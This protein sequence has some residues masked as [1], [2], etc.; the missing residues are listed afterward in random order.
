MTSQK[1]D[2]LIL[3]AFGL[4]I[5]ALYGLGDIDFGE[6]TIASAEAWELGVAQPYVISGLGLT[7]LSAFLFQG[8]G[9]PRWLVLLW[10]PVTILGGMGWAI[11]RGV[12]TFNL[13]E[14]VVLGMP[15]LVIWVWGMH[16]WFFKRTEQA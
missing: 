15:I 6:R 5:A 13:S 12:A 4:V 11:S 7:V 9:W 3:A 14:F 16:R 1:R 10:C 8:A 2:A